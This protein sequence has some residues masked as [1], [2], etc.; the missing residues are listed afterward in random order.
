MSFLCFPSYYPFSVVDSLLTI[1]LFVI[2]LTLETLITFLPITLVILS[3][4]TLC[5]PNGT[6]AASVA[7]NHR[8][9]TQTS[10]LDLL[11]P[12]SPLPR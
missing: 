8:T 1:R 7:D 2:P 10:L 3:Y 6:V 4:S 9:N 12:P 5:Y 11:P